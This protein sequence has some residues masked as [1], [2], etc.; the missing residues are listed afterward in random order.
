M[1]VTIDKNIPDL[2]PDEVEEIR[3]AVIPD[4]ADNPEEFK[5]QMMGVNEIVL[6]PEVAKQLEEMGMTPDELV[7][8]LLKQAGTSN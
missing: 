2:T 4:T 7:A 5:K 3:D 1:K 6:S 8:M